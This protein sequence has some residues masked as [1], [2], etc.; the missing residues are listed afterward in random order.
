MGEVFLLRRAGL[1]D[2]VILL[3][4]SGFAC[5]RVTFLFQKEK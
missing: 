5:W 3:I 4:F 1:I 2:E